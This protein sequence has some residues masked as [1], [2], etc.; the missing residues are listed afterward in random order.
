M[1][2]KK[3]SRK[4]LFVSIGV[5]LAV[6]CGWYVCIN[7][8]HL[9]SEAVFPGPITVAKTFIQKLYTEA[10]DGA[11]LLVHLGASLKVALLGYFLG[12]L[13]GVPAGIL[14]AWS[15]WVDRFARP[16]FDLIRPV[17]GLAWIP[18]F[19][20]LFGIGI[21]PKAAVIFLSTAVAC[22]I[23]CYTGIR[24]TRQEHLW[25]GDVFG[26]SN[27]QKLFKI[28]IPTALPMIF[29]GLRVAMGAAWMALVAAELLAASEGLGYM[30]QQGRYSSKPELVFVG[31]LMIGIV[32]LLLDVILHWVEKKV[33]KG[34]NAE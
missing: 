22:I 31:M 14:M 34:M 9:K 1:K 25:V 3:T 10:P 29:T 5:I 30:I 6:L 17:P 24:Q 2:K 21:V 32:G 28:A 12:V 27:I 20:L 26:A 33:A 23:N 16:L 18:M 4:Y 13:F 15:K 7:V 8:L 19:I 11:T